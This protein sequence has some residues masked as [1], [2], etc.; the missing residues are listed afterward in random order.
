[1]PD[2]HV[3]P[4]CVRQSVHLAPE[5][6][7]CVLAA[8]GTLFVHHQMEFWHEL[9]STSP[10]LSFLDAVGTEYEH[11]VEGAERAFL[12][13]LKLEP[14][15]VP[16]MRG[17]AQFLIEVRAATVDLSTRGRARCASATER[18]RLCWFRCSC[19]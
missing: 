3:V 15:S 12:T 8:R 13:V 14:S 1:M 19:C 7:A 16:A 18:L 11:S 5:V 10:S 2:L 17:Y 4:W 9:T 6:R